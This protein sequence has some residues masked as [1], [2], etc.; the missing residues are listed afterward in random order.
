MAH[1]QSRQSPDDPLDLYR[2]Q[3][4][5]TRRPQYG[6]SFKSDGIGMDKSPPTPPSIRNTT[7]QSLLDLLPIT[8][9]HRGKRKS[10]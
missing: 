9:G 2:Q 4:C 10:G 3:R 7:Q 5:H 8:H 6:R 1:A